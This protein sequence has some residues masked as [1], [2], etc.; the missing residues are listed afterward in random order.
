MRGAVAALILLLLSAAV[1]EAA[2]PDKA[3][4]CADETENP[5]QVCSELPTLKEADRL[6]ITEAMRRADGNQASAA[7]LLGL[8]RTAL[9]RRLNRDS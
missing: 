5:F 3:G 8:T 4:A 6:L 7:R 1:A 9:N 2:T